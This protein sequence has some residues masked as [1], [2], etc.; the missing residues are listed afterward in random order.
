MGSICVT[1]PATSANLGAGFDAAG[2]ALGLYNRVEFSPAEQLE[3]AASDGTPVP[4]GPEN[5]VYQAVCFL[6]EKAG[7]KPPLLHIVQTNP[8]PMARGLGSS[9]ACIVAGL[10]GANRL[11]GDPFDRMQLLDFATEM[12]G[13]P[14]NVAPALLGGFVRCLCEDGKVYAVQ[15]PLDT[16][17][18]FAAVIPD[19]PLLTEKA[20]GVLPGSVSHK[21]AVF[22]LSR[23]A[24]L[25]EAFC[26][27]RHELLALV[28]QDRLHQPYRMQL[29]PGGETVLQTARKLGA[30][31]AYLSG[32]GSTLLAVM[33]QADADRIC[34]GLEAAL[35]ADPLCSKFRC[36]RLAGDSRG[37]QVE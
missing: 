5:L 4:T 9:S 2:L 7:E 32:A 28:T 36:V 33:E 3:I 10:L 20:R 35:A 6:Y 16:D 11:L 26:G 30:K 13:H 23:A 27:G 25:D 8:I 34:A 24:L 14:D 19:Q 37:A 15:K 1:V 31:A 17:L 18:C 22:N 29:I 21:D 12:E